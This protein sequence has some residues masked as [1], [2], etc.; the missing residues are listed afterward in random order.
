[1][2]FTA[3]E[4]CVPWGKR[5]LLFQLAALDLAGEVG[6]NFLHEKIVSR[7]LEVGKIWAVPT[8]AVEHFGGERGIAPHD[9][10]GH[11][12][13]PSVFLGVNCAS[14]AYDLTAMDKEPRDIAF[15]G[16]TGTNASNSNCVVGISG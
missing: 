9:G 10:R 6:G 13:A 12:L 5:Q 16:A 1:M 8:E 15:Q 7:A 2:D 4:S 3:T 14:A 11:H